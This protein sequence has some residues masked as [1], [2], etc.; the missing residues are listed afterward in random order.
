MAK[1]KELSQLASLLTVDTGQVTLDAKFAATAG[2][3]QTD[4]VTK[5]QLEVAVAGKDNTDEITEGSTNLYFTNARVGSYLTANNYATQ[6]YVGTQLANLVDSSPA[7]LDTLNELAAALGDDPNFATTTATAIGLKAP[8]ASPSFTGTITS[9]GDI[10]Q[11]NATYLK[12]KL[13]NGTNTRLFGMNSSNVLYIGSVDADHTGGTLFVK[14]GVTQAVIDANSKV[15]FPSTSASKLTV[16]GN[17]NIYDG[18]IGYQPDTETFTFGGSTYGHYGMSANTALVG[19]SGYYGV[20]I[21]TGGQQRIKIGGG[22]GSTLVGIGTDLPIRTLQVAQAGRTF[23]TT[24][25]KDNGDMNGIV[26]SSNTNLNTMQGIWFS[27]GAD[28]TGT[29][30]SGIAGARTNYSAHW[31]THLS[32]YTHNHDVSNI[33]QATEKLR[34]TGDGKVGI[35][36]SNP[37]NTIQALS[38]SSAFAFS[39]WNSGASIWLDG[40]DGDFAGGDYYGIHATN[41]SKL[42]MG[43]GGNYHLTLDSTGKVGVGTYSPAYKLHVVQDISWS[44][45]F[46]NHSTFT[47]PSMTGGGLSIGFGKSGSQ[48]NL[49]KVVYN[50]AGDNSSANSLGLGFWDNDNILRVF[51]NGKVTIGTA[52]VGNANATAYNLVLPNGGGVMFGQDYT[53]GVVGGTNGNLTLTANAYPANTGVV[54]SITFRSGTAGGGGPAE[55]AKFTYSADGLL[56]VGQVINSTSSSIAFN[57]EDNAV[58]SSKYSQVYQINNTNAVSGREFNWKTGG[59]GYGDGSLLMNLTDTGNLS[60]TNQLYYYNYTRR[61]SG[62]SVGEVG[63]AGPA[64]YSGWYRLAYSQSSTYGLRGYFRAH[65]STTGNYGQPSHSVIEGYKDWSA[66]AI[67]TSVENQVGSLFSKFRIAMDSNYAYLEGYASFS[68]GGST[69][70]SVTIESPAY[71]LDNWT[72]YSG[73]IT[74]SSGVT[75]TSSEAYCTVNSLSLSTPLYINQYAASSLYSVNII[76]TDMTDNSSSFDSI[77]NDSDGGGTSWNIVKDSIINLYSTSGGHGGQWGYPVNVEAGYYRIRGSARLSS[78]NGA[79]HGNTPAAN[80]KYSISFRFYISGGPDS[81]Q[82]RWDVDSL[83]NGTRVS[84]SGAPVYLSAGNKQVLYNT[85]GYEGIKQIYITDLFLERVA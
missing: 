11:N 23:T 69:A 75:Y 14:N 77:T 53:Y 46:L 52:N 24:V 5:S 6:S 28:H 66:S 3:A 67:I 49:A 18:R 19:L 82:L 16:D 74:A 73:A 17:I 58:I 81:G 56:Q 13:S 85:N 83:G 76:N 38:G 50:H 30:W 29:H 54:H 61:A 55:I 42:A 79:I 70:V 25:D 35:N 4:F 64:S 51:A 71:V 41:D 1:S 40:I 43:I 32:F 7:T 60:T 65:I 12:G 9:T 39:E 68:I 80:Y 26:V 59:K 63:L 62:L 44:S 27:S 48:Y 84:F 47:N 10:Q 21:F 72:A 15:G 57:N 33:T 22:S 8:S 37:T 78:T 36:V 34:I 20:G 45:G 2:T 31:G